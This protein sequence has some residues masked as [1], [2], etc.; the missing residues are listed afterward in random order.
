MDHP[1][2]APA[3]IADLG[4]GGLY[5]GASLGGRQPVKIDLASGFG[6]FGKEALQLAPRDP[7]RAALVLLALLFE[8]E[9][10]RRTTAL[11]GRGGGLSGLRHGTLGR[12]TL[13][14]GPDPLFEQLG[15]GLSGLRTPSPALLP[16]PASLVGGFFASHGKSLATRV[17]QGA[18]GQTYS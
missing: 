14:P 6:G 10:D 12:G 11:P 18:T 16:A 8:F 17:V 4:E 15:E 1:E 9:N 13:G 3:L 2:P 5:G 7:R